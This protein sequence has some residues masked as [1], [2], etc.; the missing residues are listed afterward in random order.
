MAAKKDNIFVKAKAYHKLHP[1]TA[2]A[3]CIQKVKGKKVS[4]TKKKVSGSVKKKISAP[5]KVGAKRKRI[6]VASS[7]V[8]SPKKSTLQQGR[9]LVRRIEVLELKRKQEKARELKDLLQLEI[10]ACHDRLDAIKKR[11]TA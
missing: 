8:S 7:R 11:K 5:A 1:K 9:V 10:N 6:P 4:G 2:W 3:D